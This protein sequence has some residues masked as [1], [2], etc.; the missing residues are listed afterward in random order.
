MELEAYNSWES[1]CGQGINDW[2][3]EQISPEP[4]NRYHLIIDI[5]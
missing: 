1:S 2:R 3:K 4:E 5:R